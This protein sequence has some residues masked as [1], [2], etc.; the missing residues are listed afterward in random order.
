MS[1]QWPPAQLSAQLGYYLIGTVL[2]C[3]VAVWN[4]YPLVFPDSG[5]Y[6]RAAIEHHNLADRP[7]YYSIFIALIH[8]RLSL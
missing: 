1:A 7:I 2:L 3:W 5:A 6:I 8:L 4:G